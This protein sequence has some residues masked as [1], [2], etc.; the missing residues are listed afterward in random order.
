MQGACLLLG[1]YIH[2]CVYL[3]FMGLGSPEE[4]MSEWTEVWI[5]SHS[6]DMDKASVVSVMYSLSH[7]C[8]EL[9]SAYGYNSNQAD[10]YLDW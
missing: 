8:T 5:P 9:F 7:L 2:P 6:Q 1:G 10:T 4:V 3:A